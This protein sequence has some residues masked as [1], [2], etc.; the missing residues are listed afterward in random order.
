MTAPSV[1]ELVARVDAL[2]DEAERFGHLPARRALEE[3]V[4]GGASVPTV[5][6]PVDRLPRLRAVGVPPRGDALGPGEVLVVVSL[7]ADGA[8]L[9]L[10]RVVPVD[11][12]R[13]TDPAERV[14][15]ACL[16]ATAVEALWEGTSIATRLYPHR[17]PLDPRRD[18]DVELLD[19]AGAPF[20]V[21]VPVRGPSLGLAA[22]VATWSMLAD[23]P[24]AVAAVVTGAL[25][26]R[27]PISRCRALGVGRMREKWAE[28]SSTRALFV[29]PDVNL[30]E[31]ASPAAGRLQGVL[32]LAGTLEAVFGP[33]WCDLD[34]LREPPHFDPHLAV[35]LLNQ[36]Y[37]LNGDGLLWSELGDRFERLARDPRLSADGRARAWARVGACRSHLGQTDRAIPAL[38]EALRGIEQAGAAAIEGQTE[39]V[40]RTHQANALRSVGRLAD[41]VEYARS[42]WSLAERLRLLE[43]GVNAR[44]TL[45]QVLVAAGRPWD[46]LPHLEAARDFRV[47]R[48]SREAP[49]NHAYV[50]EALGR[51]GRPED[52]GAEYRLGCRN[53]DSWGDPAQRRR[54]RAF[55]DYAWLSAQ[56]RCLWGFDE[57]QGWPE[58]EREASA[59]LAG[60][61]PGWPAVGIRRVLDSARARLA[62]DVAALTALVAEA[63]E[64]V[65]GLTSPLL[66]WQAS[67]PLL[68][69]EVVLL[70]RDWTCPAGEGA[71][72][73]EA[74]DRI[75]AGCEEL[76]GDAPTQLRSAASRG[77]RD[78][79]LAGLFEVLRR[80]QF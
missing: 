46:G 61:R 17:W 11:T 4:G 54:N 67:M 47:E 52:A 45:G 74:L 78:A 5:W 76:F 79:T 40:A 31:L 13:T 51:L 56:L 35:E 70:R 1:A 32:S 8:R 39:V 63:R 44:S 18:L 57:Q 42:A 80:E 53:N 14:L 77:D 6:L 68:E 71:W 59:A 55:L 69:A 27:D 21:D 36:A 75:P 25:S 33:S 24:P 62:P 9:G 58:L 2:I 64:R 28:A 48:R 15:P 50:V 73:A 22:G 38:A 37:L 26:E 7:G 66:A 34:A 16:G 43:H 12:D 30:R 10:L 23:R 3:L 41:A 29:A 49:R 72:L 60:A 19:L 65:A 20:D